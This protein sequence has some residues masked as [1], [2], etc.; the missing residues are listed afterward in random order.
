MA[1][2]RASHTAKRDATAASQVKI[3]DLS[4]TAPAADSEKKKKF[5][6]LGLIFPVSLFAWIGAAAWTGRIS[7]IATCIAW[8]AASFIF[9]G[10][11]FFFFFFNFDTLEMAASVRPRNA[12]IAAVV[13]IA[14]F[15]AVFSAE[16]L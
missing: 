13:W 8:F 11:F 5:H 15:Y 6:P 7:G 4:D 14:V 1:E 2:A 10:I 12:A 16:A 9:S 3:L